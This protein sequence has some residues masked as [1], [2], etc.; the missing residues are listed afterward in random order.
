MGMEQDPA[1]N[2]KTH[3]LPGKIWI[4]LVVEAVGILVMPVAKPQNA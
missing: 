2:L 4:K 3:S 1:E